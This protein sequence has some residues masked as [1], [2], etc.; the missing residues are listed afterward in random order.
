VTRRRFTRGRTWQAAAALGLAVSL[1]ATGLASCDKMPLSAPTEST[2][3]LYASSTTV[4][5]NGSIEITATVIESAGTPVQNGTVVTFT[6]TL[7][8]IEPTEA[9]TNNGKATV[10]LLAGSKSGTAEVRAF[11][12]GASSGDPLAVTVG[13]AAAGK[14]E[15]LANPSALPAAGGVVQLTALVSDSVGNRLSGVPVT[16]TTDAGVLTPSSA[17]SD[18]NGEARTALST[19]AK[20]RVTASVVGGTSASLSTS[21]DIPVR[22]GPTVTISTPAASIVPG[23]PATFNVAV[24][25]GGAAVRSAAIEFGDGGKQSLS[26]FGVSTVTHVYIE[27]GVYVV[28]A[29]ATDTAGESTTSTASV[30]VQPVVVTVSMT[31]SP[32]TITTA[33]PAE[34]AASATTTPAGTTIER[35]EWNFGDGSIRTTSGST[36]SHLYT[37]GGGRRYVVSVRAVTTSGASGVAQREIVVQ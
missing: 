37:S 31:V 4:G 28:T 24:N 26:T 11:S 16:F 36:T 19:T 3:T 29:Q 17:T 20:T 7:G 21:L 14:V 25:A 1:A 18:G 22:V 15:L 30:S 2:I 33:A 5:L 34:F 27:S 23:I 13:A 9:R 12:G 6:T 35:Y 8:T 10:R 32:T